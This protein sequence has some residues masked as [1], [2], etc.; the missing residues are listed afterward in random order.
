MLRLFVLALLMVCMCDVASSQNRDGA[1]RAAVVKVNITPHTPQWLRGY[2][3][4]QS[5]SIHDSLY[6]KIIVLDDGTTQLYLISSDIIGIPSPEYDRMASIVEKEFGIRPI[7]FWWSATHTHSA[8]EIATHFKGISFPS[9]ANRSQLAAQHEPDTAYTGLLERKLLEGI[10]EARRKLAPARFGV[11]WGF[12]QANINRRAIDVDGKASLGLNPDGEVDRKI[13]LIRIDR[14]DGTPM[15]VIANY[16]IHGTVLGQESTVISGD[17]PGI[18]AQYVEEKTGA[19]LLFIN[20]AAGNLAPI[21]S[22]YPNP[23]AGHLKQFRRLLGDRIIEGHSKIAA[24]HDHIVLRTGAL[25]VETPRRKDIGWSNDIAK[26]QRTTT[27]GV[28]LVR[29][30][31]RF[32]KINSDVAIWSAPLEMFCEI[33]NEV[34]A[35]SPF[36]YTFFFGYTNG[37]LGYLPDESAWQHGGY[38]PGVSAFTPEAHRDLYEAVV[39]YLEGELRAPTLNSD[40]K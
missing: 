39:G 29:L 28:H 18:V 32:L 15:A 10:R 7:N 22:V 6:H 14:E 24:T 33:S 25:V 31:I 9:M 5:T 8:P 20:G 35:Q 19:P 23:I 34:R 36:S 12:S 16:A 4:R 27:S 37:S 26:Y 30:P 38:E 2:N 17:V 1:F 13:G 3:P 40:S 11:G 21:Y